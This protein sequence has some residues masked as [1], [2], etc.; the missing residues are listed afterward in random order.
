MNT[1]IKK[2]SAVFGLITIMC[3][4]KSPAQNENTPSIYDS[5]GH[6]TSTISE[7]GNGLSSV[8]LVQDGIEIM[9]MKS[10]GNKKSL[11]EI[12]HMWDRGNTLEF[13]SILDSSS[14]SRTQIFPHDSYIT[15]EKNAGDDSRLEIKDKEGHVLKVA[16]N[17]N[18][19]VVTTLFF[20]ASSYGNHVPLLLSDVRELFERSSI[21]SFE[22]SNIHNKRSAFFNKGILDMTASGGDQ[23][24]SVYKTSH[25]DRAL[26]FANIHTGLLEK[27][28]VPFGMTN[29]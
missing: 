6:K 13:A 1:Q 16:G 11:K 21:Q 8:S 23:S 26:K 25:P 28:K 10:S 7:L 5:R 12:A 19:T 24:N 2:L 27:P 22:V 29:E 4:N 3:A 20:N 9:L 14:I 18:D 17:L 15:Y